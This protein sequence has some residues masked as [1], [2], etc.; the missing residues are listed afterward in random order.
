MKQLTGKTIWLSLENSVSDIKDGRF[1][2]VSGLKVVASSQRPE[3]SRI[4]EVF[5]EKPDGGFEPLDLSRTYTVTMPSFIARGYDGFDM[6]STVEMSIGEEAAITDTRLLLGI[7]GN[8]EESTP[9]GSDM[10]EHALGMERARALIVVDQSPDSLPI[11]RPVVEDRIR[12][13][14]R[15]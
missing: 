8:D 6:F 2:Q 12:F 13:V 11:V 5:F 1:V 4:L 9:E 15:D 10:S 7:F 14:D 3:G